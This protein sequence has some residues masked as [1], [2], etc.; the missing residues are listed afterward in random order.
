YARDGDYTI[1]LTVTT[2]DG[3]SASATHGVSVRT[4]D[5]AITDFKV[6]QSASVGQTKPFTVSVSNTRYPESVHESFQRSVAGSFF[7]YQEIGSLTQLG[8]V[9]GGNRSTD[10]SF[11]YTFT[12]DDGA[13]GK[14][15]FQAVA[16]LNTAR[17][18]LGADNEAV[19]GPIRVGKGG[20]RLPGTGLE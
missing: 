20:G 19:S 11:S 5:V 6:P 8:P 12:P 15:T 16:S 4:H 2:T 18:A 10:F 3:R 1:K 14:V 17:D 9:R 13:V 7:D